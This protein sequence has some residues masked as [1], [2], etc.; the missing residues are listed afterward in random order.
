MFGQRQCA[1]DR[2]TSPFKED[3][4]LFTFIDKMFDVGKKN[5]A[6]IFGIVITH[7][8]AGPL[9]VMGR[10]FNGIAQGDYRLQK[11]SLRKGDELAEIFQRSVDALN[12]LNNA[13]KDDLNGLQ[14]SL[15]L[16]SELKSKGADP[17]LTSQLEAQLREI[18]SRRAKSI[19]QDF[20]A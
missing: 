9:F 6:R 18:A 5:V 3:Q 16:L 19:G 4:N 20:N 1:L 8:V 11:R 15:G 2:I 10:V 7:R 17:Q 12:A 13:S 14:K